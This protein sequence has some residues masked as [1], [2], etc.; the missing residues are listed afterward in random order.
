[1]QLTFK[2]PSVI[3]VI[4]YVIPL[5]LN[6]SPTFEVSAVLTDVPEA[7]ED[8]TGFTAA[9]DTGFALVLHVH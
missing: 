9:P 3:E 7:A 4:L 2:S 8:V 5:T 6:V 1:M